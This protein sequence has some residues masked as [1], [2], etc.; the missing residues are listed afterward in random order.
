VNFEREAE[1]LEQNA[2]AIAVEAACVGQRAELAVAIAEVR[3]KEAALE[4]D[5]S[6]AS[7]LRFQG[8]AA[9]REARTFKQFVRTL[10]IERARTIAQARTARRNCE[11]ARTA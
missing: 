8:E 9:R 7:R 3:D 6:A 2:E 10:I 1:L 5:E 4:E 11:I